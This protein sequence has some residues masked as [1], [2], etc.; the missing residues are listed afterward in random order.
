MTVYGKA[1][2]AAVTG[3]IS[4]FVSDPPNPNKP[5]GGKGEDDEDGE[6][7]SDEMDDEDDDRPLWQKRLDAEKNSGMLDDDSG[8]SIP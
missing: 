1:D 5:A 7:G 6:E 3:E 2:A 8:S 4:E